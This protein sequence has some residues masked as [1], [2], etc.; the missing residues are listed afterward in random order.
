MRANVVLGIEH[1]VKPQEVKIAN[2]VTQF[3][4]HTLETC[5]HY[6]LHPLLKERERERE[7]ER[8]TEREWV[9]VT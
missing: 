1:E 2:P 4:S 8:E 6:G 3:V 9:V 5:G 7:R